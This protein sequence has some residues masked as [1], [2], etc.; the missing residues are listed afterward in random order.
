MYDKGIV[1][2]VVALTVGG[3]LLAWVGYGYLVPTGVEKV[4]YRLLKS[5]DEFEVRL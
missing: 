5:F 3:L 2:E 1:A 4:P